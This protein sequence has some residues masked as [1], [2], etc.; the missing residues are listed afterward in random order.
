DSPDEVSGEQVATSGN[1]L[2]NTAF[3]EHPNGRRVVHGTAAEYLSLIPLRCD[4]RLT[5][6]Q[7]GDLRLEASLLGGG[8]GLGLGLLPLQ[9]RK[10]FSLAGLKLG[11]DRRRQPLAAGDGDLVRAY[12]LKIILPNEFCSRHWAPPF[13]LQLYR[14]RSSLS[15]VFFTHFFDFP[16]RRR[17]FGT[18]DWTCAS[19][20]NPVSTDFLGPWDASILA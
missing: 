8:L 19:G 18:W 2:T 9:L 13:H 12:E 4:L 20:D 1:T 17:A 5:G 16:S 6:P 14:T 11:D 15:S 7:G 10:D 3:P